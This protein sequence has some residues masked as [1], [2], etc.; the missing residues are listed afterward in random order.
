MK[1]GEN[2]KKAR[3]KQSWDERMKTPS[4]EESK[5]RKKTRR[6]S[7]MDERSTQ[8][9]KDGVLQCEVN[10]VCVRACAH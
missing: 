1:H 4:Q 6:L 5:E 7:E 2:R 8:L 9:L 10:S 3:R